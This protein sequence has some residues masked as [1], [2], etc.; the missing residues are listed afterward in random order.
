MNTDTS[1]DPRTPDAPNP[2]DWSTVEP[3]YAALRDADLGPKDLPAWLARWS[4]LQK[5]VW[6][7][8]AT[9]KRDRSRDLTDRAAHDTF[10]RFADEVMVPFEIANQGLTSKLLGVQG[11]EPGP[12]HVQMMRQLRYAAEIAGGENVALEA[13]IDALV[14]EY[15]TLSASMVPMI[16]GR[17]VTGP[18][19]D[20]WLRDPHRGMREDA[21]RAATA[22]WIE[23]RAEVEE[24]ALAI[25]AGRRRLAARAG[26]RDYREYAW[27]RMGHVDYAPSDC[28]RFGGAIE[29]EIV[30]LAVR[31]WDR[32]RSRLGVDS[33][34]PWDLEVDPNEHPPLRPLADVSAFAEGMERFFGN[35]NPALGSLFGRMREGGYLDLGWR[36]GKQRGGEEWAFPVTGMPYVLVG[37]DG[38]D[39]GVEL[40]CH[41]IG[42]AY[43]DYLVLA[44]RELFWDWN[45]PDE[46]A[47]FAAISMQR[48]TEPYLG[49]DRG[50]V[51]APEDAARMRLRTLDEVATKWLPTI[52]LED[53]FQHWLYAEA[54]EDVGTAELDA[55]WAELSSRYEPWVDWRGLEAE[56]SLGWR[57]SGAL[58]RTPFYM[59][60]YGLAHLGALQ[61]ARAARADLDSAWRRYEAA[62]ACGNSR[63]LAELYE[64]AGVRLPFDR[65]V[66][67]EVVTFLGTQLEGQEGH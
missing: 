28:L 8:R 27:R 39:V 15:G 54:P 45:Y 56:H 47:E 63:P 1:K 14:G 65:D 2:Y 57:R 31:L 33:L 25:L 4:E 40:L 59:I 48:L 49:R 18:E 43:H 7:A 67:R 3:H 13:E 53:A 12:E 38:T 64:M 21:W 10:L 20:A 50:G 58:P 60:S 32:R 42:H 61:V 26:L 62:L 34:R 23:S 46:M 19:L 24:L 66:V 36:R 22:T 44:R 35:V 52:A 41:E 30:P 29:L 51:L 37:E 55:K 9:L 16:G 6:E 5:R 11:W 17:E